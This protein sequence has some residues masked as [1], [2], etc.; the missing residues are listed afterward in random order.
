MF[1]IKARTATDEVSGFY[2]PKDLVVHGGVESP[3]SGRIEGTVSGDVSVAAKLV[4][5]ETGI[6]DGNISCQDI[7]VQGKVQ[8][9]ITC[10]RKALIQSG[11]WIAGSVTS[12]QLEVEEN[13]T[14][15][16]SLPAG[17][18]APSRPFPEKLVIHAIVGP[19]RT[20]GDELTWF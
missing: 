17:G 15:L 16:K 13:A 20:T 5:A 10:T 2:I 1:K 6:V 9:N 18:K 12:D 4:I 11:A 3:V 14:I 19:S 8:G 7:I